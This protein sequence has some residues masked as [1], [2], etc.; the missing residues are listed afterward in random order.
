MTK[1]SNTPGDS[2]IPGVQVSPKADQE[3]LRLRGF[4]FS[5]YA[6]LAI[7]VSY[8]P[9]YFHDRGYSE[10]Q[11]GIIYSIGP[12]MS[13][14]A[15]L[16]VGIASDK[17]RT[18]RKLLSLLLLGQ[19]I[20][21]AILI[22]ASDFVVVCFIMAGFYFFQQ[23][24]NTLNDSL[25]LLSSPHI[26]RSY[27]SIRIFGSLGF[28]VSALVFGL[29]LKGT[30]SSITIIV[31]LLTIAISFGLSF[32]LTDHQG[33]LRKMDFS[34]LFKLVAK[35]EVV[36]FFVLILIL[37]TA[38]R[39][40]EGFLAVT[41]SKMGASESLIGMAWMV[42]AA[43]EIPMLFLLG[44]Y[45][46]KFKELAL[47]SIAGF[48]YVLR[49]WLLSQITDPIWAVFIQGFHSISFAIFFSTALRYLT[50]LIPDEYRASGQ[51]LY[52]VVWTGF[53]GLLS[54]MMGGYVLEHLGQTSF[55]LTAMGLSLVAAIGFLLLHVR[56]R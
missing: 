19:L 52:A 55:Y 36:I 50:M 33:S 3:T 22:P 9:I 46:H 20:A 38:H 35:P 44:K 7:I 32:L 8:F 13:I 45:G 23:P 11:I 18:I 17:Y 42:S 48:A 26:G 1:D 51:A 4:S 40:N 56:T 37:S 24:M 16:I 25:I 2:T 54:G 41:M 10:Q 47:L 15:N 14:F 12:A 5:V 29:F 6:T 27:P 43:S 49:F 34:G 30:D 53:A 31:C 28:A 21:V 39:M